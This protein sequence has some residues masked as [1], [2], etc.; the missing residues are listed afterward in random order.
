MTLEDVVE[1]ILQTTL[2]DENNSPRGATDRLQ[3]AQRM[4]LD[5]GASRPLS[6]MRWCTH[7]RLMVVMMMA[8]AV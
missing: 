2:A 7:E 6:V 4:T 3:L 5:Y 1:E 8:N